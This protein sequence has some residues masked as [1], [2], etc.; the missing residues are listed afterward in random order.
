MTYRAKPLEVHAAQ[1]HRGV[2]IPGVTWSQQGTCGVLR[3]TRG[4]LLVTD[5]EWVV[6]MGR[7]EPFVMTDAQF[8]AAFERIA[9]PAHCTRASSDAPPSGDHKRLTAADRERI[10]FDHKGA[11]RGYT[12]D[13]EMP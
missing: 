8:A 1:W 6:R 5:G 11:A 13:L 2:S 12:P 10:N 9:K 4:V 3:T 7:S